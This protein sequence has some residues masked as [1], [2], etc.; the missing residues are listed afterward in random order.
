MLGSSFSRY[1]IN[2][3]TVSIRSAP[4]GRIALILGSETETLEYKRSTSELEDALEDIAAILNKHGAGVLYFG[5]RPDG[6]VIGQEITANTLR[7]VSQAIGN[8]IEPKIYPTVEQVVID[9]KPCVRVDFNGDDP[10]YCK[11]GRAYIRVADESLQMNA[12]ELRNY[13]KKQLETDVPWDSATSDLTLDDIDDEIL[14]DYIKKANDAGRI[15][16]EYTDVKDTLTRL[17]LLKNGRLLN[18]AK[19]MFSTNP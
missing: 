13:I 15:E 2:A 11:R 1:N 6:E 16:W 19:A 8:H 10:P 18:T 4:D 9:D 14:I 5:I 3:K 12:S 17:K 7:K